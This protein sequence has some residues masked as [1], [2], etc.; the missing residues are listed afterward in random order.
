MDIRLLQKVW[1]ESN[2]MFRNQTH[3]FLSREVPQ[4]LHIICAERE[5][6]NKHIMEIIQRISV[7]LNHISFHTN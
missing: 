4:L 3:A 6:A 1:N 5:S 2:N 7:I